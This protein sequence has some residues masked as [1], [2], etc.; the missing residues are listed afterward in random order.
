VNSMPVWSANSNASLLNCRR[1]PTT[2]SSTQPRTDFS[3]STS[4]GEPRYSPFLSC[5]SLS[6]H[7]SCSSQDSVPLTSIKFWRRQEIRHL[8][9]PKQQW[10][11]ITQMRVLQE[12]RND[13]L[14]I[15]KETLSSSFQ[16]GSRANTINE[17]GWNGFVMRPQKFKI[18]TSRVLETVSQ[19]SQHY[20]LFE[21]PSPSGI[22]FQTMPHT[23]SWD[24]L[25][26][27]SLP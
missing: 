13:Y 8:R 21:Y 22:Y 15:M 10:T 18:F 14:R 11:S 17:L 12:N 1:D 26:P 19:Q 23:R 2:I 20:Y 25:C 4:R 5:N 16:L 3:M 24:A 9:R 6:K 7:S 27:T